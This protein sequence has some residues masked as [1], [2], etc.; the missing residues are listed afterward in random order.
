MRAVAWKRGPTSRSARW[1]LKRAAG[2]QAAERNTAR[3][4]PALVYRFE[5]DV[6]VTADLE[7]A[8]WRLDVEGGRGNQVEMRAAPASVSARDGTVKPGTRKHRHARSRRLEALRRPDLE[9]R[10]GA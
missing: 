10:R 9:A 7:Q 3:C 2:V 6:F 4:R 1:P 8:P 5:A